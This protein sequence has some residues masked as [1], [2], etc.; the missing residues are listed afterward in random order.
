MY[1][2]MQSSG[3][4][5]CK[6]PRISSGLYQCVN[7]LGVT[8]QPQLTV[9]QSCTFDIFPINRVE[10]TFS[11][12]LDCCGPITES[13]SHRRIFRRLVSHPLVRMKSFACILHRK[14]QLKHT[15]DSWTQSYFCLHVC[16][17][18]C[19]L[20]PQNV[21]SMLHSPNI[22]ISVK[23]YYRNERNVSILQPLRQLL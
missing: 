3:S 18:T 15:T 17:R 6:D 22:L 14:M 8:R 2:S 23:Y 10:N 16:G 4:P 1:P 19:L 21:H 11:L 13:F 20:I 5:L 12:A 9:T 7:I